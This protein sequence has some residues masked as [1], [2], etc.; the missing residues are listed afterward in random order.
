MAHVPGDQGRH[1]RAN[2]AKVLAELGEIN[3][4][5]PHWFAEGVAQYGLQLS[6]NED[7]WATEPTPLSVLKPIMSVEGVHTE[8]VGHNFNLSA[9]YVNYAFVA[10][11]RRKVTARVMTLLAHPSPR[12]AADAANFFEVAL[13]VPF[14]AMNSGPPDALRTS[15]NAEFAQTLRGLARALKAGIHPV[16][17]LGIA[18][19]VNWHVQHGEKQV[20]ATARAVMKALPTDTH[21]RALTALADGWGQIFVP[22]V[23][24]NRWQADL[25]AWLQNI[26]AA[27]ETATPQPEQRRAYIEAALDEF[28]PHAG[29]RAG[30]L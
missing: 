17:A 19:S 20:R 22:I 27:I 12:V 26:V 1:G 28:R 2:P 25:E 16:A 29:G 15:L 4:R 21:F 23:D 14:G 8:A 11:W 7:N 6:E 13:R 3:R 30:A 24:A 18:K 10:P 9:Y 5:N